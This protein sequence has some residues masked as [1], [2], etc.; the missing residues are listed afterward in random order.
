MSRNIKELFDLTRRTAL[1]AGPVIAVDGGTRA[2]LADG[3]TERQG[4]TP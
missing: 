4:T 1:V 3:L 2:M